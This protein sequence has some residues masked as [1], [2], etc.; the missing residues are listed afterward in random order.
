MRYELTLEGRTPL[1]FHYD[2]VEWSDVLKE[3]RED[4]KNRNITRRGDDRSPGF[5]WLGYCYHDGQHIALPADNLSKCLQQA[6]ARVILKG[7][8]TFKELAA[9]GIWFEEEF[10]PLLID[11]KPIPMAPFEKLRNETDFTE[12]LAAAKRAGFRLWPKRAP[13]GQSKHVRVRPRFET[14]AAATTID[15]T[16]KEITREV[17]GQILDEAGRIGVGSWRPG[18]K[19]PGRFGMFTATFKAAK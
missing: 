5:T 3:W 18:G 16:A 14:W 12:H 13:I 1:L 2:D 17:L 10:F 8:K 6:G 19:T 4:P 9:S 15:V 11:G 7:M